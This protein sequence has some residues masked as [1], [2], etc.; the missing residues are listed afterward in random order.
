M[1]I[2]ALNQFLNLIEGTY[3]I[4]FSI[5]LTWGQKNKEWF[6]HM[7]N[8]SQTTERPKKHNLR[9]KLSQERSFHFDFRKTLNYTRW[10]ATIK[11]MNTVSFNPVIDGARRSFDVALHGDAF[12]DARPYQL[13]GN[14]NHGIDWLNSTVFQVS[15]LWFEY[16]CV[17]YYSWLW[18]EC[19]ATSLAGHLV[20][21]MR[22]SLLL[23]VCYI[24]HRF[25][26]S[27]SRVALWY[28]WTCKIQTNYW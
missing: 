14:V 15:L 9:G 24:S 10:W 4:F 2:L 25:Y 11:E 8:F 16:L 23:T 26:V 6:R 18:R 12:A 22:T 17:R 1:L 7:S 5:I 27:Q 19:A 28:R 21:W 13:A 20:A 3:L